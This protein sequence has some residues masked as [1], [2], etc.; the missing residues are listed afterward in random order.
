MPPLLEKEGR[1]SLSPPL[2]RRGGAADDGVVWVGG[3]WIPSS[4]TLLPE[5]EGSL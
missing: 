5:G 1:N 3:E 4:S 2:K